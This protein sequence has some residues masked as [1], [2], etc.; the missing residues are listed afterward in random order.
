VR[1]VISTVEQVTGRPVARRHVP[2]A[3]EPQELLA[4]S[5][6]IQADLGWNPRR[7]DLREIIE[8]AWSASRGE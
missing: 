3:A 6:A 1:D 8:D 4:D 7:S 2:P 5:K